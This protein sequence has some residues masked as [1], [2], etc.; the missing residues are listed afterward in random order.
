M[1]RNS[2]KIVFVG[3][4]KVGK[5][6]MVKN[7]IEAD[8]YEER[9]VGNNESLINPILIQNETMNSNMNII[10]I[11]TSSSQDR[12]QQ[13]ISEIKNADSIILVY[14]MSNEP[15]ITNLSKRWLPLIKTHNP[16]VP[17]LL[18]GNKLDLVINDEDKYVKT[19]VRRV[20]GLLFKDFK[21]G[22]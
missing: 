21:V 13:L 18:I 8:S 4:S 7:S 11:D 17:V 20:I 15:T 16:N 3:D 5:T 1:L 12:L 6:S 22:L 2:I 19:K 14:D 10:L 9:N